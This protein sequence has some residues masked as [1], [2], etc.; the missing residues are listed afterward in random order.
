MSKKTSQLVTQDFFNAY[1]IEF[2]GNKNLLSK[3]LL[4]AIYLNQYE[5]IKNLTKAAQLPSLQSAFSHQKFKGLIPEDQFSTICLHLAQDDKYL[6]MLKWLQDYRQDAFKDISHKMVY[7]AQKYKAQ[8]NIDFLKANPRK[9]AISKED[10]DILD[11]LNLKDHLA[12]HS[13]KYIIDRFALQACFYSIKFEIS[14]VVDTLKTTFSYLIKYA[15]E[16][17]DGNN[18]PKLLD[19]LEQIIDLLP[20]APV[21]SVKESDLLKGMERLDAKC[22]SSSSQD[23]QFPLLVASFYSNYILTIGKDDNSTYLALIKLFGILKKYKNSF[24]E[25]QRAKVLNG[26][27]IEKDLFPQLDFDDLYTQQKF[28]EAK[29]VLKTISNPN[30]KKLYEYLLMLRGDLSKQQLEEIETGIRLIKLPSGL[31]RATNELYYKALKFHVAFLKQDYNVAL[32]DFLESMGTNHIANPQSFLEVLRMFVGELRFQEGQTLLEHGLKHPSL[33]LLMEDVEFQILQY[34]IY[35]GTSN[36]E[37][38]NECFKK[39]LDALREPKTPIDS[40]KLI[41][42][43]VVIEFCDGISNAKFADSLLSL[44]YALSFL[45]NDNQSKVK[46]LIDAA[47][48]MKIAKAKFSKANID[49][50]KK[51]AT[52]EPDKQQEETQEVALD[53]QEEKALVMRLLRNE[54]TDVDN[55]ILAQMDYSK[56]SKNIT[57]V[58]KEL[59]AKAIKNLSGGARV[60]DES[61]SWMVGNTKYFADDFRNEGNLQIITEGCKYP[62]Y[63]VIGDKMK[64]SPDKQKSFK[65]AFNKGKVSKSKYSIGIEI[66]DGEIPK[67]KINGDERLYPSKLYVNKSGKVLA[68]FDSVANHNQ[69]QDKSIPLIEVPNCKFSGFGNIDTSFDT[70][71]LSYTMEDAESLDL[72][73]SNSE[74]NNN[75]DI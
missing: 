69:I 22:L 70:T 5:E 52:P 62:M 38:A 4:A 55:Q 11:K 32:H 9:T 56:L 31:C 71:V 50:E 10:I 8:K 45:F 68:I 58:K 46:I 43:I 47:D 53:E 34:A 63:C 75:N 6:E 40:F 65:S 15:T 48:T 20:M 16:L 2:V 18:I 51:P 12:E 39:L 1:F 36:V 37:K 3:S 59:L 23:P 72:L 29:E 42:D 60:I 13:K 54:L 61:E 41:T 66:I 17:S 44:F 19:C 67:V 28:D 24:N 25:S 14:S 74:S 26:L 49:K 33:Q 73:G 21:Q 7:L 57:I 64:V 35:T 30:I 27:V